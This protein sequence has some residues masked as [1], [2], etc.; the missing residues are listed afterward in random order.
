MYEV[1]PVI[2]WL[3]LLG[4]GIGPAV[5]AA[6]LWSPFLF[7]DRIRALFRRLPPTDS[8]LVTYCLVSVG[9]WL[10]Y[11]VGMFWTA[12][13]GPS[14]GPAPAANAMLDVVVTVSACY[15]VGLP[16]LAGVGLPR[17]GIDWDSTGYGAD[18]WALIVGGTVWYTALLGFPPFVIAVILALPM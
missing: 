6:I 15:L 16:L 5:G 7:S 11:L 1:P 2:T 13:H 17:L 9:L 10:P 14:S 8:A 3:I 12:T 4:I 18:T